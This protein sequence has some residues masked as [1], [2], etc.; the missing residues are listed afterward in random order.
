MDACIFT[1]DQY[2]PKI[3]KR[4]LKKAWG[5]FKECGGR[6]STG[7]W[8][9]E[10]F[11]GEKTLKFMQQ[12]CAAAT[13]GTTLDYSTDKDDACAF[14]F[15]QLLKH[16]TQNNTTVGQIYQL[17]SNYEIQKKNGNLNYN[18]SL[19][20]YLILNI[21]YEHVTPPEKEKK[22]PEKEKKLPEKEKKQP[23]NEKKQPEN[24]KKQPENEKKT[25]RKREK[26]TRKREKTTRKF[27]HHP[28][29]GG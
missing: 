9:Y 10:I 17:L 25:T 4:D 28:P 20:E 15:Q 7:H 2:L 8:G 24:E 12:V 13:S 5:A 1:Q 23:E 29:Q 18:T 3:L 27:P 16:C 11:S 22:Q 26:T 6:I 14:K 21:T 19:Y